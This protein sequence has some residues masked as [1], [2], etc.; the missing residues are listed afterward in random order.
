M[1]LRDR[2]P[3][4]TGP[5][6]DRGGAEVQD[7]VTSAASQRHQ[8]RVSGS[9]QAELSIGRRFASLRSKIS[10]RSRHSRLLAYRYRACPAL[11]H[12]ASARLH[13][14]API[15]RFRTADHHNVRAIII[16]TALL[17]FRSFRL[18]WT[19]HYRSYSSR[20]ATI[21]RAFAATSCIIQKPAA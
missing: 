9:L 7:C 20:P 2:T 10:L 14:I 21:T 19:S 8:L 18:P 16:F 4:S 5:R 6:S 3:L 1:S 17:L 13:V 12:V 15:S 11:Y